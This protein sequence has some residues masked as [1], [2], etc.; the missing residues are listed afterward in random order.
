MI[1]PLSIVSLLIT[2]FL[3]HEES[4]VMTNN[5]EKTKKDALR[6]IVVVFDGYNLL[7]NINLFLKFS[8]SFSRR[9]F[10]LGTPDALVHRL[11]TPLQ[12][13]ILEC[14]PQRVNTLCP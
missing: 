1:A 4:E 9:N 14:S 13:Q 8:I 10:A 3:L 12:S 7:V 5:R 2:H 11:L 6:S